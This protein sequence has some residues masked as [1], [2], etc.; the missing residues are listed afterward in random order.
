M[1]QTDGFELDFEDLDFELS[2]GE[3]VN[4]EVYSKLGDGF[5]FDFDDLDYEISSGEGVNAEVYSKQGD[6]FE[7]EFE[8][9]GFEMS[10][11]DGVVIGDTHLCQ[12]GIGFT[13]N[14]SGKFYN[15]S[16]TMFEILLDEDLGKRKKSKLMPELRKIN[17]NT[18][19]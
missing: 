19:I 15:Y 13:L 18:S 1:A 8:D 2:S 7:L 10:S 9:F 14:I 4:T 11:R 3:G 12:N 6:G 16:D 5:E 17:I